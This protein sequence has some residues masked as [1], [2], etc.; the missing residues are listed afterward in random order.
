[1]STAL[2]LHK[3]LHNFTSV[4][5][6]NIQR[7]SEND[8]H[9][10][11]TERRRRRRRRRREEMGVEG[12]GAG[13]CSWSVSAVSTTQVINTPWFPGL[14]SCIHT[15][16]H[17]HTHTVALS[18]LMCLLFDGVCV[19]CQQVC[20]PV[21]EVCACTICTR[22]TRGGAVASRSSAPRRRWL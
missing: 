10:P 19:T 14:H 2:Q 21:R 5:C 6:H 15:H 12:E 22:W 17:T 7:Y 11:K 16:I 4:S 20:S 8:K 13:M 3:A 1:M 9:F 18:W